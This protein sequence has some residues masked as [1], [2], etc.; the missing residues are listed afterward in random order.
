MK[1]KF[2]F[3][4]LP[5]CLGFVLTLVL[6]AC[7]TGNEPSG[8]GNS[9]SS[10][11]VYT[12]SS[13]VYNPGVVEIRGFELDQ[14]T[15]SD[16]VYV[17]GKV[18][19][20]KAEPIVRIEFKTG[21]SGWVIFNDAP[22]TGPINLPGVTSVQLSDAKIDLTNPSIP[23][24]THS[25]TVEACIDAKCSSDKM[26]RDT[27]QFTKPETLCAIS[28]SGEVSSSSEAVWVF[29]PGQDENVP[30][31]GTVQVGS[32]SFKLSGDD[33]QP[34]M[35]VYGGKVRP[36]IALGADDV[37]PGKSYSSKESLLGSTPATEIKLS[38]IRCGG[39]PCV[40]QNG[41]YYLIYLDGGDKYLVQ[42]KKAA[43][44]SWPSWPKACTF[45][46]ATVSP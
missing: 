15:S 12:P 23:C 20:T 16:K 18:E 39:D 44:S 28:S 5:L 27:K 45:W 3:L 9:S 32:G 30:L 2:S 25:L 4:A 31:N 41:D 46:R 8:G 7:S 43:G 13:N 26:A 42:F 17:S 37:E 19:A 40:V 34:D 21:G 14:T 22:V 29:A 33:G 24:G 11:A 36:V 6:S 38:N 10:G 35:E 1:T